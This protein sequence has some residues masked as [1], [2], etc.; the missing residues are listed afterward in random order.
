VS[1]VAGRA[2]SALG[3]DVSRVRASAAWRYVRSRQNADGSWNSYWWTSPHFATGQAVALALSVR[4]LDPVRRAAVWTL[5]GQRHDGGWGV[6]G[7]AASSSFATALSLAVLAASGLH[8]RR[9]I[10]RGIEALVRLQ[11]VDGA[12]PSHP[13]LRIP[14]PADSSPAGDD[15]RRLIRFDAGLVVPDQ[16]RTFTSATCVAALARA[17]RAA[18]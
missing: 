14:L 2:H 13:V 10:A 8:D 9:P 17:L 16:H 18:G 11:E 1:A 5:R 12:W 6:P 15:R 4:D 3:S 7:A